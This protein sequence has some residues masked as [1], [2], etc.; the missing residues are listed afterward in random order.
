MT[1]PKEAAMMIRLGKLL[2]SQ[3]DSGEE[4]EIPERFIPAL[5][6]L[7]YIELSRWTER[8]HLGVI[9]CSE[10]VVT[11]KGSEAYFEWRDKK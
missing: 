3:T 10:Y 4:Y 1:K 5:L 7:D 9:T 6:D 8:T 2:A 11:Q